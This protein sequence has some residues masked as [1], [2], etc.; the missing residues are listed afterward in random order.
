MT[1]KVAQVKVINVTTTHIQI[2]MAPELNRIICFVGHFVRGIALVL[3]LIATGCS[4]PVTQN[5]HLKYGNPSQAGGSSNNYLLVKP[6]Y[7]LSYSCKAGIANWASWQLDRH[8]LGKVER[9]DDFRPD[10]DLPADCYAARP[11]DYRAS[12]YDRG[13][14]TPSGDRT[15]RSEDN[16]NTFL[17]SNIIPQSPT[18]NREVW[19]ELE[20][21]SRELAFQGSELYIVAGV[22]GIARKIANSQI[23]VPKFNWKVILVLEEPD[24]EITA[25][26][27]YTIAAWMPNS[28]EVKNMVWK[29]YLVSVDEVEQK[30]GYD[31]FDAIPREIQQKI[32]AKISN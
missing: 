30:T 10:P 19:R 16:S 17:M 1:A 6:S 5:I 7:V 11:N 12:G 27:S 24:A 13:H 32:E 14:L 8:W 31:F 9:S 25:D 23:T 29:D 22:D 21:Y 2:Q 3:L 28:E 15:F 26:N 18:N 4:A 20:E